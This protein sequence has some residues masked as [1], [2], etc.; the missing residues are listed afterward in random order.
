MQ[1]ALKRSRKYRAEKCRKW[2]IYA[3]NLS[4][5]KIYFVLSDKY[6]Q[7]R[8]CHF[9]LAHDLYHVVVKDGQKN[10]AMGRLIGDGI[11]FMIVDLVVRP[12]YQGKGIGTRMLDEILKYIKSSL[13]EGARAS[14]QLIAEK[15]KENFYIKSGFKTIPHE[16]CGSGMRKVIHT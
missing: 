8:F 10:I 5:P 4:I 12:E 11:Y 13:P 9:G 2:R 14:V 3:E 1:R 7:V 15:G 16:N 6:L